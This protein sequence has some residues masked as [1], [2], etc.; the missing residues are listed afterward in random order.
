MPFDKSRGSAASPLLLERRIAPR[1]NTFIQ[2]SIAMGFT[3]VPCIV[4]N[5][6]ESGAKLEVARVTG[7]PDRFDLIVPG[8]RP[9]P[10][11]VV[12]RSLK[13]IG[14]QYQSARHEPADNS[15]LD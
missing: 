15:N 13:E 7:I 11:R 9:Q 10:C 12:W 2:A 8:H 3:S 1:R 14:V 6:S 5:V 4:R